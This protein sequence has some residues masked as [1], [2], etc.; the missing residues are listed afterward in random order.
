MLEYHACGL[1]YSITMNIFCNFLSET[2]FETAFFNPVK[3]KQAQLIKD[4]LLLY[5]HA[6]ANF[7]KTSQS[8]ALACLRYKAI[9]FTI[10]TCVPGL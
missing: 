1:P 8:S 7:M 4:V 5:I 2:V 6:A 3:G 10:G 9:I